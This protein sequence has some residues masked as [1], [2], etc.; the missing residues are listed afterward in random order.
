MQQS[1]KNR[2]AALEQLEAQHDAAANP[3]DLTNADCATL[4]FQVALSNV[5]MRDGRAIKQWRP[6]GD[7]VLAAL[8][9]ALLRLNAALAIEPDAPKTAP[10][11]ACVLAQYVPDDGVPTW[12]WGALVE[13]KLLTVEGADVQEL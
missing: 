1:F 5:V 10:E 11:L 2:I 9:L 7:D 13:K 4:L 6:Q 3:G 8:D 12:V